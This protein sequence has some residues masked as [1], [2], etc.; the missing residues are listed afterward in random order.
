MK[1][2]LKEK[3]NYNKAMVRPIVTYFIVAIYL[4]FTVIVGVFALFN[5]DA[6]VN[7]GFLAIYTGL[8]T[9]TASIVSFWFGNRS[10]KSSGHEN[11]ETNGNEQ[12]EGSE[13]KDGETD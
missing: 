5:E 7:N 3:E 12:N 11:N 9:L 8:S 1:N 2:N 13:T 6:T 4:I 10:S